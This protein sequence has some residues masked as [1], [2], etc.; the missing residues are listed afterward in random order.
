MRHN[1][2]NKNH[3]FEERRKP[4]ENN[5]EKG[6]QIDGLEKRNILYQEGK[7]DNRGTRS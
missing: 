2:F 5:L 6:N 3:S 4:K 7:H 1:V